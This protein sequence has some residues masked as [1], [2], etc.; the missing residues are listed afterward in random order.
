MNKQKSYLV[1]WRIDIEAD[2]ALDAAKEAL[3]IQRDEF[4]EATF[5]EVIDKKT[6]KTE[7][8]DVLQELETKKAEDI[9]MNK[10]QYEA[11]MK[12][13]RAKMKAKMEEPV[14]ISGKV[15]K[16]GSTRITEAEANSAK[17]IH[18]PDFA[19]AIPNM[20]NKAIAKRHSS[21]I[22]WDQLLWSSPSTPNASS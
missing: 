9:K 4:A 3:A 13:D 6:K 18:I 11:E 10:K 20:K 22:S 5:F 14:W 21:N 8:V 2:N 17:P 19:P 12:R 7:E 15:R 1:I 16:G